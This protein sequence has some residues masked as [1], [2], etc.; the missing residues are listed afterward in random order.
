[1]QRRANLG[2][3]LGHS[4]PL[5]LMDEYKAHY[6]FRYDVQGFRDLVRNEVRACLVEDK[7]A[8]YIIPFGK[9]KGQSLFEVTDHNY[10]YFLADTQRLRNKKLVGQVLLRLKELGQYIPRYGNSDERR[11]CR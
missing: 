11:A 9:L 8:E 2:T 4:F 10:L 5:Y 6:Q 1:M 3:A 7:N